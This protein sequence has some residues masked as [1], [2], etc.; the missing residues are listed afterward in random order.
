[1]EMMW[2]DVFCQYEV[3][4]MI[5]GSQRYPDVLDAQG[6]SDHRTRSSNLPLTPFFLV[7][8]VKWGTVWIAQHDMHGA[9]GTGA[10]ASCKESIVPTVMK[11]NTWGTIA[12][13]CYWSHELNR[14]DE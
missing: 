2:N 11:I 14:Q 8:E 9:A 10:P 6:L 13:I 4:V 1:M 5:G 3:R 12:I 7:P